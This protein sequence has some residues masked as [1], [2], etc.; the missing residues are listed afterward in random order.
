MS[1]LGQYSFLN[2]KIVTKDEALVSAW[3]IGMLRGFGVYDGMTAV[4]EKIFRFADH[5]QRFTDGAHAL[6]LNI[7]ITE[8]SCEKTIKE[9][10]AKNGFERSIIRM[11]LTGGPTISG[12]EFD[13][14]TPT[15]YILVEEWIA[16]PDN[17]YEEGGKLL[18]YSFLR[19]LPEIKTINYINAVKLQNFR[20]EEGAIEILYTYEGEVLECATSNI[21]LVKDGTLITPGDNIL[22][23][24]TRKAVLEL[25]KEEGLNIEERIVVEEELPMAEE[26]FIT[27]SFKDIVPITK[28]DDF[29]IYEEKV[30]PI[31]QKI[32]GKLRDCIKA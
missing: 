27:S 7:P 3:D 14:A 5:W 25:A 10:L 9:L 1:R 4:G 13:F 26:I 23:G 19:Q 30:G 20:K 24:I 6:D 32:L 11:I 8:D 15:F 22:K 16:L 31:T 18:T 21:F 12:I 2:G 28:I 29:T 17:L